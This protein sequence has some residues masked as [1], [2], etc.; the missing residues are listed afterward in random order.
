M[1]RIEQLRR[2]TWCL[3]LLAWLAPIHAAVD[4]LD[5]C[6]KLPKAME[7]VLE[8]SSDAGCTRASKGSRHCSIEHCENQGAP[9]MSAQPIIDGFLS[10]VSPPRLFVRNTALTQ[11]KPTCSRCPMV[12]L[13]PF[14]TRVGRRD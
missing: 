9:S 14:H 7:A 2:F 10:A 1:I 3:L 8:V 12:S 5:T 6:L 13:S 11:S 4:A